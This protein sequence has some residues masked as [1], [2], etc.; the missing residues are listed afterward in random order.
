MEK[1]EKKLGMGLFY[2]S[3]E[4]ATKPFSVGSWKRYRNFVPRVSFPKTTVIC[5]CL[6]CCCSEIICKYAAWERLKIKN[7]YKLLFLFKQ[8]LEGNFEMTATD[9]KTTIN[10]KQWMTEVEN[11]F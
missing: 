10:E 3:P 11:E 9:E 2:M 4:N 1:K 8:G 7:V 5:L 6:M